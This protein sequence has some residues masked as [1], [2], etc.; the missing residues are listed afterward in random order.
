MKAREYFQ[1]RRELRLAWNAL[2]R[3]TDSADHRHSCDAVRDAVLWLSAT[4][5]AQGTPADAVAWVARRAPE[6]GAQEAG[7]QAIASM[8]GGDGKPLRP[9]HA[10]QLLRD[11]VPAVWRMIEEERTALSRSCP[12]SA[13]AVLAVRTVLSVCIIA[14]V[15]SGTTVGLVRLRQFTRPSGFWVTYYANPD[16]TKRK[17]T[18]MEVALFKDY[19]TQA[20]VFGMKT[21]AWSS[22]WETRLKVTQPAEYTFVARCQDG[23]RLYIDDNLLIDNWREQ[24]WDKSVRTSKCALTEGVHTVIVEHAVYRGKGT[25]QV[26]WSGGKVQNPVNLSGTSFPRPSLRDCRR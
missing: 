5:G 23:M 1:R 22:R 10:T 25:I 15:A 19:G 3:A 4:G 14:A 13:V 26:Q 16:L 11:S 20:P 17:A 8:L 9:E 18:R 12:P 7:A 24:E 21:N 6:T 2:S